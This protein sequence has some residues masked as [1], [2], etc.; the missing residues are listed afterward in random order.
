[1]QVPDFP[2]YL[3][4]IDPCERIHFGCWYRIQHFPAGRWFTTVPG[5]IHLDSAEILRIHTV[6]GRSH[7]RDISRG[8]R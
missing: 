6:I 3:L 2:V 1:M 4:V 8:E 7:G 5:P